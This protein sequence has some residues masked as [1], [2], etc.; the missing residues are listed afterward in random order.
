MINRKWLQ[1]LAM[2]YRDGSEREMA[3]WAHNRLITARQL[4]E[5]AQRQALADLGAEPVAM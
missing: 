4:A 3:T 2:S 1:T 5:D